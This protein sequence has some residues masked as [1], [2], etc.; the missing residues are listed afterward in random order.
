MMLW[1]RITGAAWGEG[2]AGV[3]DS[4][5]AICIVLPAPSPRIARM[6][7]ETAL[8]QSA[9]GRYQWI[10]WRLGPCITEHQHTQEML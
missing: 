6:E 2:R 9:L 4:L 10:V 1:Y 7:A 3:F 8:I 5:E